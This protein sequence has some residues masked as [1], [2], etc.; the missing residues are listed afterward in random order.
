MYCGKRAVDTD[1]TSWVVCIAVYWARMQSPNISP[2]ISEKNGEKGK[3]RAKRSTSGD[4]G[5]PW[6][7]SSA[8]GTKGRNTKRQKLLEK[9]RW[10]INWLV[11][12]TLCENGSANSRLAENIGSLKKNVEVFGRPAKKL[13]EDEYEI[14]PV[15]KQVVCDA[16]LNLCRKSVTKSQNSVWRSR[17]TM[18]D[19]GDFLDPQGGKH[20]AMGKTPRSMDM[21][22]IKKDG[23]SNRIREERG[24]LVQIRRAFDV[25][26]V[27]PGKHQTIHTYVCIDVR[28]VAETLFE[29]QTDKK[30]DYR[31]RIFQ[32]E[33]DPKTLCLVLARNRAPAWRVPC[34]WT[35]PPGLWGWAQA[36]RRP[37]KCA[38]VPGYHRVGAY[39][40]LGIEGRGWALFEHGR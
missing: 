3:Q 32:K 6:L 38:F 21:K 2:A 40:E 1:L 15:C 12:W 31:G 39:L 25:L 30:F 18:H 28:R 9:R 33:N 24:D 16:I 26:T 20:L 4:R 35:I 8:G 19:S 36:G 11:S 14:A 7:G 29:P 37:N 34:P 5:I 13:I 22:R 27:R 17:N 10:K 23:Q